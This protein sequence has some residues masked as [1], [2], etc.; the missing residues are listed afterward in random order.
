MITA[1][2]FFC[3]A[4]G[5]ST[6][7][8]KA[9]VQ[10]QLA[11]N[12]W[13]LAIDTHS[14]NHPATE[15][16][17]ND[18]R[19]ARPE[20]YRRTDIAWF[21]P[22]CTSHSLAKGR[23]RKGLTQLDLWGDNGVDP[24]EERSRAT[25]REVVEFT[26][27]HRYEMVI[28]E[29]VVD[30]RYW[31]HYDE[32]LAAMLDLGYEHRPLYLN[33]Q[34]FGVPQSRD[35]IYIVFW[36]RGL[37]APNLDFRPSALCAKHGQVQAVQ[38]FKKPEYVWGRYG[39]RRQYVYRCPQCGGEV[40]PFY[41]PAAAAI[42]WS[43][44]SQKIGDR[45]KPLKEKT[46]KRIL[47]GL[48]KFRNRAVL[49]DLSHSHATDNGKV[50]SV[51]HPA[52]TQT[53]Q[54]RVALIDPF[55]AEMRNHADG[56]AI[57]EPL[58]TVTAGGLHHGLVTPPLLIILKG[59]QTAIGVDEPLSTIV[60]S[61]SQHWLM[62][63]PFMLSGTNQAIIGRTVDEPM[64]ATA[65]GYNAR[66]VI[67]P[68]VIETGGA[69]SREPVAVDQALPTQ[70]T[71]Q[72]MSLVTPPIV[73]TYNNNPV[74]AHVGQPMPTVTGID[75]NALLTPEAMLPECE[76]R[77]LEPHELKR[78]MSFPDSYVIL[79]NKRDQVKQV[80]NAVACNVAEW[81]VARCVDALEG[82]AS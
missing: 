48:E 20:W 73:M 23:K 3:G 22:E 66:L 47:A 45:A 9:G 64:Y 49:V 80:G 58:G 29:N 5:S 8:V 15:H 1:T 69:P 55:I 13:Q 76:F 40:D 26:A 18:L 51:E 75:R 43:L 56:R 21:S 33:A 79:G 14:T 60:A 70:L 74:F 54:A 2:D 63:P 4:G 78:G 44:P 31:A 17:C 37:P 62:T 42:D 53:S 39:K 6:G 27:Y 7:M 25:M 38:S 10:V 34:F 67:P 59:E 28:V 68:M 50:H 12:H 71:R 57:D 24:A 16:D 41:V 81:I 65:T 52:P 32:W 77:M 46:V 19:A 72:S 82:K 30:I 36:R 11:A 35:R 61:A